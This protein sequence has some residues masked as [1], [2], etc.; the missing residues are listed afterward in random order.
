MEELELLNRLQ[1]IAA[2]CDDARTRQ[3]I[4][5]LIYDRWGPNSVKT[6]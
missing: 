2:D 5:T 1:Q 4:D 3:A 6:E